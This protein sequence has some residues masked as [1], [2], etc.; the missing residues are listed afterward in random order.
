MKDFSK[1]YTPQ[2]IATSLMQFVDF[3]DND[4]VID[5]CCGK[6][7][8]LFAAKNYNHSLKCFGVDTTDI[9]IDWCKT[10]KMDG[11]EFALNTQRKYNIVLANPPFGTAESI[12]YASKLF[13]DKYASINSKRIEVEMLIANLHL[14]KKDG[15]LLIILPITF[16]DGVS[17]KRIRKIISENHFVKSIIKLPSNAFYPEKINCSAIIICKNRNN[18]NQNCTYYVM[19]EEY[20]IS[21][22]LVIK[23]DNMLQGYWNNE[24]A[25]EKPNFKIS[26][27]NISSNMFTEKGV[28]V[29]HTA[30]NT[31]HW[32]PS[33]R[34]IQKNQNTINSI[35]AEK[36]D[37]I[38]S[39]IGSSAG[40]FCIYKGTPKFITDCLLLVKSP[41]PQLVKNIQNLNLQSLVKGVS[42]PHITATDI[43]GL[44][45]T[46]YNNL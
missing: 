32:Q 19:N 38:I 2:Q 22:S 30:K 44:Y 16:I 40:S 43:Y 35:I 10:I 6:G 46:T 13:L 29:L 45:N 34:Y 7:N 9:N 17:Y 37:I 36:G 24:V 21:D 15:I 39:R 3:K 28:E 33:V 11:R 27:G 26:R 14:L 42:T 12:S 8:L 20:N 23:Y 25:Y 41:S 31:F 18:N 4:S 5:I 1:Y